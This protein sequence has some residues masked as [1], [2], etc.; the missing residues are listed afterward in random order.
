MDCR[1]KQAWNTFC[2]WISIYSCCFLI[3]RFNCFIMFL[4]H[5]YIWLTLQF[6]NVFVFCNF[7]WQLIT[8]IIFI[9]FFYI[10]IYTLCFEYDSRFNTSKHWVFFKQQKIL[11]MVE[12]WS[13]NELELIALSMN[14]KERLI[15]F[16]ILHPFTQYPSLYM[17]ISK[18]CRF[19][20]IKF[21][22]CSSKSHANMFQLK[23]N[24]H[25]GFIY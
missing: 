18:I 14:F 20:Y 12:F 13:C 25:N 2:G 16:L 24:T 9:Y 1:L 21:S 7:L 6:Y 11:V 17:Y 15:M 10:L 23:T 5:I 22:A 19:D 8:W 4:K 3:L